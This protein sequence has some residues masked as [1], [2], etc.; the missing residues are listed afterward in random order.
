MRLRTF[1]RGQAQLKDTKEAAE[2]RHRVQQLNVLQS[3]Q[4]MVK[5]ASSYCLRCIV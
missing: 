3:M 4:R 5:Y 2:E 1:L